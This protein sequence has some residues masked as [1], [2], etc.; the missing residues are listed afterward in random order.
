MP[1]QTETAPFE[2]DQETQMIL[3]SIDEFIEQEVKPI[4]NELGETYTNPR[5][6]RRENGLLVDEVVEAIETI[7]KKSADAGFYA[8]IM[9]EEHGGEGISDLTWYRVKKH[10]ASKGV[11]LASM[12]LKGPEGP[13]PMLLHGTNEQIEEFLEP[14]IRG[15]KSAAF[16][17]TE[18][19]V[20]SDSPNMSTT[21]RKDGEDWVINGQ[22]Q[23]ITNAPFCDFAQVL[24]RT[25]P[26]EEAG[27]Y[28]GV[29]CFLVK[30]DEFEL[31]SVNNA[32]GLEGMQS[33]I[34]L[35]DVRVPDSRVLGPVDDAF[36]IAMGFLSEGRMELGAQAVGHS[37]F[38]IERCKQYAQEREA[39]G[40]PIGKF[41]QISTMIAEGRAKNYAANTA[42]LKLGWKMDQGE[43][44]V[45]DGSIFHWMAT[46]TF[47]EIADNA[48]QVHGANGLS[49][50]NPFVDH[51][52]MAR[53]LRIVEGTDEIQLNTIAKENGLL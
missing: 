33:E 52:E 15:E 18:P 2:V 6:A 9:P 24:A 39:F 43:D 38:L 28:G 45:E 41:Q 23:W 46:Q 21:A 3:D 17:Q 5:L 35:D 1:S 47:W 32:I 20:G 26:K 12:M 37:E 19:G 25:T 42:G 48:V 29:T 30:Q 50:D 34:I 22:K 27:R 44:V 10:V 16:A 8:M 7:R 11:G 36:Y 14:L 49:E 40:R 13:N 51:L 31:G 53:V 4:E